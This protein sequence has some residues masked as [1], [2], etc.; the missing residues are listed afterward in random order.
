MSLLAAAAGPAAS[1][2]AAASAATAIRRITFSSGEARQIASG[3]SYSSGGAAGL[4]GHREVGAA[5]PGPGRLVVAGVERPL[6]AERDDAQALRR[7]RRGSPGSRGRRGRAAPRAPGCTRRCRARRS[8]PRRH[9]RVAV[10]LEPERVLLERG[11]RLVAERGGVVVEVDVG[12]RAAL[13]AVPS[14][15]PAMSVPSVPSP[16]TARTSGPSSSGWAGA[17]SVVSAGAAEPLA[18]GRGGEHGRA[19]LAAARG[20]RDEDREGQDETRQSAIEAKRHEPSS[21]R[22]RVTGPSRA[23]RCCPARWP[24]SGASGPPG[25]RS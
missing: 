23:G 10:A 13:A 4:A 5:V 2:A 15:L 16:C 9:P 14:A 17:R 22:T 18:A 24:A 25:R 8:G 20:E 6:L 7:R 12:E 3:G 11:P 19:L 1:R 21:N